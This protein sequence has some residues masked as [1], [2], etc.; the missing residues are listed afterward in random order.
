PEP[1]DRFPLPLFIA[2]SL[3]NGT[4]R[5][6]F[7][8]LF[9]KIERSGYEIVFVQIRAL[10]LADEFPSV[11]NHDTVAHPDKFFI[12]CGIEQDSDPRLR[13]FANQSIHFLLCSDIDP[14]CRIV[15]KQN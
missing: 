1:T 12:I 11:A 7:Y 2:S 8:E 13:Q 15:Q 5:S 6:R 10:K 3:I 14:A 4:R 9:A